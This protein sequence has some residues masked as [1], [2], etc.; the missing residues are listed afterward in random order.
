M[1]ARK[2]RV[3][4]FFVNNLKSFRHC[5]VV[6]ALWPVAGFA[7][8]GKPYGHY[9]ASV[10]PPEPTCRVQ[11]SETIRVKGVFDGQGCLYEW[12]GPGAEFCH[13]E[14]EVS[15]KMPRMFVMHPGSTLRNLQMICSPDG[16]LMNDDTTI[17]NVIDR[18]CGEDC[19]TTRGKNNRIL[20]SAFFFCDDKCIQLNEAQ[21]VEI[22]GNT[23]VSGKIPLSGS[24]SSK[25]GANNIQVH[26]N[27]FTHVKT[28]I[29][30]Q[31]DHDFHVSG[32]RA[33]DTDCFFETKEA[34]IIYDLGGNAGATRE[35]SKGT[36]NIH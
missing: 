20:N 15:E 26:D 1:R 18:D 19:V 30:A 35:C 8:G 10:L 27:R 11:V 25:G 17:E 9:D 3:L 34:G 22:R 2:S 16:T 4:L 5:I 21:G 14:E 31:S 32:S 23:F 24:S 36:H 12:V 6:A 29:L 7:M 28:A 33:D 13:A